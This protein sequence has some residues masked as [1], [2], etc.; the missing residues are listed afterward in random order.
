MHQRDPPCSAP[1]ALTSHDE[2]FTAS[3]LHR[4][5][6]AF[7]WHLALDL[8][9]SL[10]PPKLRAP[11]QHALSAA[12]RGPGHRHAPGSN[13]VLD[14]QRWQ[15]THTSFFREWI[16]AVL[17]G[18]RGAAL[19][20]TPRRFAATSRRHPPPCLTSTSS[21]TVHIIPRALAAS[22]GAKHAEC[23]I[24]VAQVCTS[25]TCHAP[26]PARARLEKSRSSHPISSLSSSATAA[27]TPPRRPK[28]SPPAPSKPSPRARSAPQRSPGHR[29]A[30][31]SKARHSML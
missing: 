14:V 27:D 12:P 23:E 28:P 25:A 26:R 2:T 18:V 30:P 5:S 4:S 31:G 16:P 1:C 20:Y 6:T 13:A 17:P 19:S 15:A 11:P 24:R 9:L 3:G 22:Q 8:G 7:A 10:S 21:G 29:C